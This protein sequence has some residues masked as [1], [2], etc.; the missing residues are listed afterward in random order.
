MSAHAGLRMVVFLRSWLWLVTLTEVGE[1]TWGGWWRGWRCKEEVGGR[2]EVGSASAASARAAPALT[3]SL[4]FR[5]PCRRCVLRL[6]PVALTLIMYYAIYGQ[7]T[8]LFVL[9]GQVSAVGGGRDGRSGSCPGRAS[10][11]EAWGCPWLPNLHCA[12]RRRPRPA[13]HPAHLPQGMDT[14]LGSLNLAPATVGCID[15]VAGA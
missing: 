4:G 12:A 10:D 3:P 14:S 6:L 13:M 15:P 5:L 1:L 7:T 9:Q 11:H 8:T 2:S